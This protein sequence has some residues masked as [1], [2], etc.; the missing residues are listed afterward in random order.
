ML[1]RVLRIYPGYVV[2][3]L[4]SFYCVGWLGGGDLGSGLGWNALRQV[5][6]MALLKAPNVHGIFPGLAAPEANGPMWSLAEEFRCYC[7]VV[8]LGYAALLERRAAFATLVALALGLLTF[9]SYGI[10]RMA[11]IFVCGMAFYVFRD[12]IRYHWSLACLAALGWCA[13]MPFRS[14]CEPATALL[15]GYLIFWFAFSIRVPALNRIGRRTDIS[16]GLYL[17]AWPI[18]NLIVYYHGPMSAWA[19]TA[20]TL[21]LA[22]AAGYL[23]WTFVEHPAL[24][25]KDNARLLAAIDRS[26][27]QLAR[28]R[29]LP[30]LPRYP[31]PLQAESPVRQGEP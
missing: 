29:P 8:I 2:A 20:A 3:F 31:S 15:G 28:L 1:S 27:R 6:T 17:Y 13:A 4:F 19:L 23:S 30:S 24:A 18:S 12:R 22:A 10:V 25:F 9:R 5:G 26:A 14:L 21:P 11:S 16:Y 7:M